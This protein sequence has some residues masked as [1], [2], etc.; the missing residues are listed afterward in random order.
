MKQT[1]IGIDLGTTF[2]VVATIDEHGKPV[3]LK[4]SEGLSITPSV[5]AFNGN[6]IIVGN[7]A[8]NI[9]SLGDAN[10]ASFFKR[11]MGTAW[12]FTYNGNA[13]SPTELSSFVLSKLKKDAES[14]LGKSVSKAV[15]TVPAYFNDSQRTATKKAGELAGLEV[16]RVIN[17]PTAAAIVFGI[18]SAKDET[19]LVYDLGGGTFDVTL[20]KITAD[21]ITVLA[22]DGNHQLGGKDWD[23]TLRNFAV[24]KFCEEF[25]INPLEDSATAND[26]L[27]AAENLKKVLSQR[28]VA[29][30]I[31]SYNGNKGRY[32]ITR[33]QFED[34]TTSLIN[35][36]IT[37]CESVLEVK[38]LIW[39]DIDGILL[40][41]GSTRMPQVESELKKRTDKPILHGVNVDEA[42]ALGA[43]IQADLDANEKEYKLES[44][45]KTYSLESRRKI[46]DVT[47]Q[48]LGMIA[49]NADRTKYI[50]TIII[51]RN[52]TIPGCESRPYKVRTS[53]NT[54][55]EVYVTQ[56]E[57]D[58]PQDCLIQGKYVITGFSG[59]GS[60]IADIEY[61]Y[62]KSGI[63]NVAAKQRSTGKSLDI[64]R[65]EIGDLGWL[66]L[67]PID[68]APVQVMQHV[69]VLFAIDTSGSMYGAPIAEAMKAAHR[70]VNEM[71]LTHTS[72]GLMIV[73]DSVKMLC[74]PTQNGK[75]IGKSIDS[76]AN[77]NVLNSAGGGNLG[78]PFTEAKSQFTNIDGIKFL[79]VLADGVWSRQGYAVQEAKKCHADGIEIAA[80]GFG[81]AD[82]KFLHDIASCEENAIFTSMTQLGESFSKIAQVITEGK[83]ELRK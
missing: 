2:S 39:Q 7:E 81:G 42:V 15:I 16:L 63:V 13:Y 80:L 78:Q 49:E 68:R 4:N 75:E 24:N 64:C 23:D 26:L 19:L 47:G 82:K 8:K 29:A 62:D 34:S 18:K 59:K 14:V 30:F 40:V 31:I 57:M 79:V 20:M 71:D 33:Q 76:L 48:S 27:V 56:G 53:A 46:T 17:E 12:T 36:T 74:K 58:S 37:L 45:Q 72:I 61:Q 3:V 66:D 77:H 28:A 55:I 70:F 25:A 32:D 67:A 44:K 5:I 54:E 73:A 22:T 38:N 1:T 9:Q 60:D 43:A 11:Q 52:T 10:V 65:D 21:A 35:Q 50:N 83:T 69:T 51:H 41:G 6:E